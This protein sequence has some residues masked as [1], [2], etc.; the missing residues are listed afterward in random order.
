MLLGLGALLF[1]AATPS[2]EAAWGNLFEGVKSLISGGSLQDKDIAEGLKEALRIGAGNSVSHVGQIGGYLN[3][4]DIR[5]GLPTPLEKIEKN[6]PF[7]RLRRPAQR[8]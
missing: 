5:I 7:C 6:A 3:N 1:W 2:A 4:P 8:L